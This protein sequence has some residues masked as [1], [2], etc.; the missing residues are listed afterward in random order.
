MKASLAWA[1]VGWTLCA[2][3]PARAETGAEAPG[4]AQDRAALW[5]KTQSTRMTT[6]LAAKNH[7]TPSEARYLLATAETLHE[8]AAIQFRL[9]YAARGGAAPAADEVQPHLQTYRQSIALLDRVITLGGGKNGSGADLGRAHYL[10][11]KAYAEI[12]DAAHAAADYELIAR[13]WP[14]IPEGEISLVALADLLIETREYAR[15]IR[16]LE[17]RRL[18]PSD[19][20]FALA[21][22]RLAWCYYYTD[23]IDAAIATEL[24]ITAFY[25]ER[26]SADKPLKD[27]R[28]KALGNLA[29]Y[30]A[31]LPGDR[32]GTDALV[33]IE[34]AA[35]AEDRDFA[36]TRFAL[37]LRA[38]G[39]DELL[40]QA[41]RR[42]VAET[43]RAVA[44][45]ELIAIARDNQ[46]N[47][48]RFAQLRDTNATLRE[49]LRSDPNL[50]QDPAARSRLL[51]LLASG[52]ESL[53]PMLLAA[54]DPAAA[55]PIAEAL[56]T[57]YEL[58]L[59]ATPE[60]EPAEQ[61]RLHLNLARLASLRKDPGAEAEGYAWVLKR[62]SGDRPGEHE[63]REQ[64]SLGEI[65]LLR[66]RFVAAA[67]DS[68]PELDRWVARVDA[69]I[70]D[71]G[72]GAE[73]ESQAF[74]ANRALL[75]AGR[76]ELALERLRKFALQYPQSKYALPSVSLAID[77]RIAAEQWQPALALL[78]DLDVAPAWKSGPFR[79]QLDALAADLHLKLAELAYGAKDYAGAI[80]RASAFARA[81]PDSQRLDDFI[82]ICANSALAQGDKAE[83]VKY[84]DRLRDRRKDAPVA[85]GVEALARAAM[86]EDRLELSQAA[87]HYRH[88]LDE[89]PPATADPEALRR[90]Q[91]RAL[92]MAWL[93]GDA[94]RLESAL[95]DSRLCAGEATKLCAQLRGYRGL[96]SSGQSTSHVSGRPIARFYSGVS[97]LRNRRISRDDRVRALAEIGEGWRELDELQKLA[98]LPPLLETLPAA[99]RE[100]RA[101]AR[102]SG[103]LKLDKASI[104]RRASRVEAL[105]SA[106]LALTSIPSVEIQAPAW[107]TLASIYTD[108][109]Q[110]IE[111]LPIPSNIAEDDRAALKHTIR[112]LTDPFLAKRE[113]YRES[114]GAIV[115]R[116]GLDSRTLKENDQN[117]LVNADYAAWAPPAALAPRGEIDLALANRLAIDGPAIRAEWKTRLEEA[118]SQKKWPL[119]AFMLEE[120]EARGAMTATQAAAYRSAYFATIGAHAEALA[121]LE[122]AVTGLQP[123][124]QPW[125]LLSLAAGYARARAKPLAAQAIARLE[126]RALGWSPPPGS[127]WLTAVASWS[128]TTAT[129]NIAAALDPAAENR[130]PAAQGEG[131]P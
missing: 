82:S 45:L 60:S 88:Y 2:A 19:R 90:I 66:D 52:A 38:R 121:A 65:A 127:G 25:N 61:G 86:D 75:A 74:E 32:A 94:P 3:P 120:G 56:R 89:D 96:A 69:C 51:A 22:Q 107:T 14:H 113:H 37:A 99:L 92:A 27:E 59:E 81:H 125:A 11:A 131:K 110:D 15:A 130:R 58:A 71:G 8:S 49:L 108:L 28:E 10:R 114:L 118:F 102:N 72:A 78:A 31:A 123:G 106:V 13:R 91:R 101:Q 42:F 16:H 47:K 64:A 124:T 76:S 109:A 117:L 39:R 129:P 97:A 70:Q 87:A 43:P 53:Q 55:A 26:R 12:R 68:G 83:A 122:A 73:I 7:G 95:A 29:L 80:S 67:P 33:H 21:S 9:E 40:E 112:Q 18:K 41:V 98:V 24:R 62:L 48:K 34:R 126:T 105:E 50:R 5:A 20:F 111:S 46:L 17:A 4:V 103:G 54:K 57:A 6:E 119:L 35:L 63:L 128:G 1:M 77:S 84:F 36:R 104:A 79:A 116:G 100:G 85:R 23:N 115:K 44:K 30:L 93:S